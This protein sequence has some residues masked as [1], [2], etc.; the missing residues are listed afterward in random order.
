MYEM[1]TCASLSTN[2]QLTKGGIMNGSWVK[3][4][5]GSK[6]VILI[7]FEKHVWFQRKGEISE[8]T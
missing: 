8:F 6:V 3:R 7:F 4:V 1:E 2:Y 5:T